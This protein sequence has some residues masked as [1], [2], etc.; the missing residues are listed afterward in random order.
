M[1]DWYITLAEKDCLT[2]CDMTYAAT[3]DQS[4]N[5]KV[6]ENFIPLH[7]SF[8][9]SQ[10][11]SNTSY[12]VCVVCRD[13]EGVEHAS[14]IL[15]FTTA[16]V[17]Q[18]RL[19]ARYSPLRQVVE[20][21]KRNMGVLRVRRKEAVSPHTLMGKITSDCKIILKKLNFQEFLALSLECLY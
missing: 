9:I 7:R 16:E 17:A 20:Q 12:W 15:H 11:S 14:D 6:V 5:T 18:P 19:G 4:E 8:E 3:E 1:I 13:K 10:L 21:D 2:S